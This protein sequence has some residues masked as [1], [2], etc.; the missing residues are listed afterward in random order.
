M[1]AAPS[2]AAPRSPGGLRMSYH[3][4]LTA[5]GL[6]ANGLAALGLA[7][8]AWLSI[9]SAGAQSVHDR[10]Y[11]DFSGQW[12]RTSSP[13]WNPQDPW[14]EKAPLTPEYR[15]IHDANLADMRDGGQGTDPT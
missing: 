11:P 4:W 14:G 9:G 1:A 10:K 6:T 7:A 15:A 3:R 2:Q 8:L 12:N 13:R 5:I